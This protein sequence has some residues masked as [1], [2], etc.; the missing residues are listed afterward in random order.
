MNR[1][2]NEDR[3]LGS[4]DRN[5]DKAANTAR[6]AGL[7]EMA[8][9]RLNC[10]VMELPEEDR[11]EYLRATA[12]HARTLYGDH[13]GLEKAAALFGMLAKTPDLIVSRAIVR[14]RADQVFA[15]AANDGVRS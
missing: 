15:R 12:S 14:A 8:V 9:A 10:A 13:K 6:H 2:A 11:E 3:I 1:S 4:I 7:R 5:R